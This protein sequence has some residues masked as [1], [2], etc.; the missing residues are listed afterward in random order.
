MQE[1]SNVSVNPTLELD[2]LLDKLLKLDMLAD[3][4]EI[5]RL[6]DMGVLIPA[7]TFEFTPDDANGAHMA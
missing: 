6:K 7:E 4:L 2:L 1:F 5:K 3:E